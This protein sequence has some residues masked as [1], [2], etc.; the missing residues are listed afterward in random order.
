MRLM[1]AFVVLSRRDLVVDGWCG[2]ANWSQNTVF[3][4]YM[5]VCD[6]VPAW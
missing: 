6:S 1:L 3:K 2:R 5:Q 4:F